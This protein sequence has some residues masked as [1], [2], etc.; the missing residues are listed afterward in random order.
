MKL[1][2]STYP[3]VTLDGLVDEISV[4]INKI[5]P[6]TKISK[7]NIKL[8]LDSHNLVILNFLKQYKRVSNGM[9]VYCLKLNIKEQF[10]PFNSC[11]TDPH[12]RNYYIPSFAFGRS[13][14][15]PF[16]KVTVLPEHL[17]LILAEKE[18]QRQRKKVQLTRNPP[19]TSPTE[20]TPV[21]T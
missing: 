11:S 9:G 1:P 21:S 2:K 13:D 17:E 10:T 16:R 12:R 19:P 3:L 5:Y 20:D 6:N 7:A 8:V 14:S 15:L 4:Y 18:K